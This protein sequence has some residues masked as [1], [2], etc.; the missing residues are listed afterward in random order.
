MGFR[1]RKHENKRYIYEQPRIIQQRH[2]CLRRL[3]KNRQEQRPVVYLDETWVNAHHGRDTLWVDKDGTAGWK[4][5]RVKGG[6]L[7]VLHA[8]TENG[9]VGGAELVFHA[10]AWECRNAG[11]E[12]TGMEHWNDL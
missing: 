9:W 3:R 2:D 6:R 8:G 4:R 5:P 11:L 7:I 12:W 1:Y 10:K